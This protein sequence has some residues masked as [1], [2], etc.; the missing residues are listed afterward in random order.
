M[1]VYRITSEPFSTDLSGEGARLFGGR[2]NPCGIPVLYTSESVAL[3]ALEVLVNV[4]PDYLADGL[5]SLVVI[6]IPDDVAVHT[7]EQATLP[8]DWRSYPAPSVLAERGRH[9]FEERSALVLRV[10]AVVV[11]GEGWNYLVNPRHP[12]YHLIRIE[13]ITPFSF[14]ARL[15]S[16]GT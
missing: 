1:L 12:D 8:A 9:W 2:W 16:K 14:D 13:Q 10:P 7:I 6:R 15:L 4:P 11:C 5:F 3:A